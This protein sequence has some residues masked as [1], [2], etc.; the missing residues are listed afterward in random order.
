MMSIKNVGQLDRD[1]VSSQLAGMLARE[2]PGGRER[3][4]EDEG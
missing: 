3:E 2:G 1:L 4:V